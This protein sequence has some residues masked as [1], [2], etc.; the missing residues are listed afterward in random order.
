[1][2]NQYSEVFIRRALELNQDDVV[3]ELSEALIVCRG[4]L[5]ILRS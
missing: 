5:V 3:Q 2:N 4:R 1:M